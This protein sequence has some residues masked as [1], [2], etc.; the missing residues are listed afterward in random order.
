MGAIVFLVSCPILIAGQMGHLRQILPG[1]IVLY[2]LLVGYNAYLFVF[3]MCGNGLLYDQW[4]IAGDFPVNSYKTLRG[5]DA[6]KL[7]LRPTLV[8]LLVIGWLFLLL[9]F[10]HQNLKGSVLIFVDS[11]FNSYN[12]S[13]ASSIAILK[14]LFSNSSILLYF[15][16]F[17]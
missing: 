1:T 14:R 4:R 5:A 12:S 7:P 16:I 3:C 2:P 10:L 17:L 13:I 8:I 15:F 6:F 11:S 9:H